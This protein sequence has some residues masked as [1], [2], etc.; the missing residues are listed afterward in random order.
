MRPVPPLILA[1]ASP[2]RTELLKHLVPHFVVL[3][4]RAAERFT[5]GAA[6]VQA[7][8]LASSKASEV[9][10]R[11]RK[12]GELSGWVLGADT[13][14]VQGSKLLAKPASPAAAR[15]MLASLSGRSHLVITGLALLPLDPAFKSWVSHEATRVTFRKLSAAEIAAYV[16]SGDPMDKA[17]AYGIQGAAGAFVSRISGDYFNVVGLPLSRLALQLAKIGLR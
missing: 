17:G 5:R 16:A 13:I 10:A 9:V 12:R 8:R 14:V 6:A 2:R 1:S 15:K 3:P 11:L 4:S 7:K